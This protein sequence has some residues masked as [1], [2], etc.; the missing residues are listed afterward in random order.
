[1]GGGLFGQRY[2]MDCDE[3][4][5]FSTKKLNQDALENFISRL[6]ISITDYE[7]HEVQ[8]LTARLNSMKFLRD[9]FKQL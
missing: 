1:M 8:F 3:L 4:Q 2:F 5:F 6:R 7:Q 9:E